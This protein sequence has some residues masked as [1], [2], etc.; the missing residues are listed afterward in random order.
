MNRL[1][2]TFA[3]GALSSCVGEAIDFPHGG[4]DADG[5]LVDGSESVA[6]AAAVPTSD[7]GEDAGTAL[8]DAAP[9][10]QSDAG[11]G[12]DASARPDAAAARPD[13]GAGCGSYS[14]AK[15]FTCSADGSSRLKCAA[16]SLVT[17]ACPRG[18]LREASGDDVCLGT[19]DGW[20]CSGS[21]GT[22]KSQSGDYFVTAFGCWTDSA[23]T[24]HT[25]PGDNCI[26]S[27]LDKART[28]GV[29]KSNESG[30]ACEERVNW[31]TADGGR[32]G[33]LARLKVTNPKNG[34]AVI[35]V[36]LDYGPACWVEQEVSKPLLDASSR[37][38]R[39][40]FGEDHGATDKA[41]VHVIEVDDTTPLG[42]VP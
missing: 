14:G 11:S 10:A 40:L 27:C 20:S 8:A 1:V 28:S 36:V 34:K 17:E 13:A 12:R 24:V 9:Q 33:C 32:F 21:W 2:F 31:F 4:S 42:P 22:T 37:V 29:C 23:G 16:G 5:E 25:D 18:C 39:Q 7:G 19:S 38:N 3:L 6:D 30:P 26:P 15:D 35:A 41:L